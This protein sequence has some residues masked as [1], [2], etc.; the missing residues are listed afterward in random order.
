MRCLPRS[1]S[2][3]PPGPQPV[4]TGSISQR[5]VSAEKLPPWTEM[6]PSTSSVGEIVL[7]RL[8]VTFARIGMRERSISQHFSLD[9][10]VLREYALIGTVPIRFCSEVRML[11]EPAPRAHIVSLSEREGRY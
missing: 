8:S 1:L 7:L 6:E 11:L 4:Q 5:R 2:A 3:M 10:L 9:P